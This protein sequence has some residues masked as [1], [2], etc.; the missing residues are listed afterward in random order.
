MVVRVMALH[1]HTTRLL[2]RSLQDLGQCVQVEQRFFDSD[3]W[4]A[5]A[6]E[7]YIPYRVGWTEVAR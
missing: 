1:L 4:T 2:R 5:F 3:F 6:S 7:D